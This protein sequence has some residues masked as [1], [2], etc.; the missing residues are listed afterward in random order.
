MISDMLL[1]EE[2]KPKMVIN[3]HGDT[4]TEMAIWSLILTNKVKDMEED[5]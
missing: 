4:E 1:A 3:V 5:C 2:T